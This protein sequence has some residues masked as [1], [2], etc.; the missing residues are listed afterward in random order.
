M[1]IFIF[2]LWYSEVMFILWYPEYMYCLIEDLTGNISVTSSPSE[3][4]SSAIF[5]AQRG[6]S[7]GS[8][9]Q[10]NLHNSTHDYL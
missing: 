1:C 2:M 10:K 6:L 8:K 9:A 5:D 3:V 7:F 4:N